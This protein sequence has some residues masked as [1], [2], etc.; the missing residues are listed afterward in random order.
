MAWVKLVVIPMY[1]YVI[2]SR[3]MDK[4][5]ARSHQIIGR[6]SIL[7]LTRNRPLNR[8]RKSNIPAQTRLRRTMV[9]PV[10]STYVIAITLDRAIGKRRDLNRW[11]A[12]SF[13]HSSLK[14]LERNPALGPN[15]KRPISKA[16]RLK[17]TL[18]GSLNRSIVKYTTIATSRHLTPVT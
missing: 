5:T 1:G 10:I 16:S 2:T 13:P 11:V 12:P 8:R 6:T 3:K 7:N 14:K 15:W 17:S 18:I 9:G 4:G